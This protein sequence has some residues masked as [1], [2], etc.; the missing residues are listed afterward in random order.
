MSTSWNLYGVA[1]AHGRHSKPRRSSSTSSRRRVMRA[2]DIDNVYDRYIC[3]E[4]LKAAVMVIVAF[5]MASTF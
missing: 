2:W 3:S 4:R 1:N 5:Y